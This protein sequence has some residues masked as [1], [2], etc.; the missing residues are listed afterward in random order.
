[1]H[2]QHGEL[3]MIVTIATVDTLGYTDSD[4]DMWES[5]LKK[6]VKL[7]DTL[8]SALVKKDCDGDDMVH[9]R[10]EHEKAL[11]GEIV[12]GLGVSEEYKEK[13]FVEDACEVGAYISLDLSFGDL[14]FFIEWD[15]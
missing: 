11:I 6:T 8:R 2:V 7:S 14:C 3:K 10:R 4:K 5:C 1:M 13:L 9:I 12:T 15:V